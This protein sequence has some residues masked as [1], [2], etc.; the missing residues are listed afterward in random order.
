MVKRSGCGLRLCYAC[1][2]RPFTLLEEADTRFIEAASRK[3]GRDPAYFAN[4][5]QEDY[6]RASARY[7]IYAVADGV[8]LLEWII[9]GRPYPRPSPAGEVSRIFCEAAAHAAEAAYDAIASPEDIRRIFAA[10]NEAVAH[11]QAAEGRTKETVDYW[12]TDFFAATAAIAVIKDGVVYWGSIC[13]SYVIRLDSTGRVLSKTPICDSLAEA[14]PTPY[15]GIA[16]DLA[17]RT[18]Y[19]WRHL[20]NRLDAAG[21]RV[22]YG[23]ITGEPEALAYVSVGAWPLAEGDRVAVLT[24]GFEEYLE[25][26]DFTA[27]LA[28]WPADLGERIAAYSARRI[29]DDPERF[30]HERSLILAA[31]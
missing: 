5:P 24:D 27:L 14:A 21:K 18:K 29:P 30:G 28:A 12:H 19:R 1:R 13:D 31:P 26:S 25:E 10:G 17:A 16:G 6:L 15:E 2:M 3:N 4:L 20:R 7:P 9:E 11:Y 22:G 23:V 8:T